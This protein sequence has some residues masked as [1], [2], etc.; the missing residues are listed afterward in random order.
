MK[1]PGIEQTISNLEEILGECL[2]AALACENW[3]ELFV[4]R[5]ARAL[6]EAGVTLGPTIPDEP[7]QTA[8]DAACLHWETGQPGGV[9]GALFAAYAAEREE[10]NGT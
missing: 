9:V 2:M 3:R 1:K 6:A 4:E 8:I 10:Q 7:S 5:F